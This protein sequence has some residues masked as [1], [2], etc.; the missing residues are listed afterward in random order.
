MNSGTDLTGRDVVYEKDDVKA[1]SFLVDHGDL[2]KPALGFRIDYG[3]RSTVISGDTR[4]SENLIKLAKGVDL[5]IHQ[6]AAAVPDFLKLP[7]FKVIMAQH[8]SP[9]EAGLVFSRTSPKLAVYYHF[10]LLG[11]PKTPALT[12]QDVIDLTRKNYSGPLRIGEDLTACVISEDRV[13][14]IE[15][16]K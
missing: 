8:T 2:I 1:T 11:T 12:E 6:V 5:L 7:V 16:K 13:H 10:A 3:G 9:E 14:A 4:Y 15:S